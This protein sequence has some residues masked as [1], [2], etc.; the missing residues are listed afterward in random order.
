MRIHRLVPGLALAALAL[1]PPA[2]VAGGKGSDIG[3]P[4]REDVLDDRSRFGPDPRALGDEEKAA[5]LDAIEKEYEANKRN[6]DLVPVRTRRNGVIFAGEMRYAPAA[7][8]L[9][10]AFDDDRDVRTRVA[11]L[12][13]I[14][15]SGDLDTIQYAVKACIANARKDP[16]FA[17]SLPRMFEHVENAEAREWLVTRLN[18]KDD[19]V[20]ASIVEAVGEAHVESAVPELLKL[21]DR[22]KD[23]TVRFETLRA[24]GKCGGE[25]AV[26]KLLVFLSD[27]DWRMRMA[28]VE[29]LGYAGQPRVIEEIRRLVIRGEEQIVVE[30][31]IEALGRLGTRDAIEPLIDGLVVARLRARQKARRALVAIARDEFRQ[32]KD[33]NVDPNAWR[34]WWKK[35]Q[36]GVDPDDPNTNERETASYFNFPIHSDRVLFILDVSG[37]MDWPDPARD[38]GIRVSDW[39]G[40][41]I[42]LAHR[43]LTKAL[44]DLA[45]QNQ[46]RIPEKAKKGETTDIPATPDDDGVE[47]PTLFNIATF[48]GV[49]TP[50][51]KT[52]VL[53][54]QDN[55]NAALAWMLKQLP[56]GGT[57][58]Y[59]ALEYGVSLEGIDTVYFLSDGVPSLGRFEEPETILSEIRKRNRFR[60]VSINTIALIVGL[61][62]IES[63]RKYEDPQDMADLMSRIAYENQGR[64]ANESRP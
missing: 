16:V 17:S 38:S 5:R 31:A 19:D 27:E 37:S 61:S 12:V 57:A 60:R 15:K 54:T 18:Q 11:A 39:K 64:F 46:G 21:L 32:T 58:T 23:P 29:G 50:W 28:A 59:D 26:P 3:G 51:Q 1:A 36:R 13:A 22:S 4:P 6:Q 33:F 53:A 24:L 62:P 63:V 44:N 45:K 35:V 41:R 14:G 25:A 42:D 8:F 30:T 56:R 52:P 47:P 7:K 55:V 40:R 2:A 10:R 43:E 48:A 34:G 20:L 9:K 49:V